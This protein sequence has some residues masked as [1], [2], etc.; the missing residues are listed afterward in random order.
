M[1]ECSDEWIEEREMMKM[2]RHG[3]NCY[4]CNILF[5]EREAGLVI[6]DGEEHEICEECFMRKKQ[7][8]TVEW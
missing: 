8:Y 1:K 3:I 7:I 4:L 2:E 5:D 6:I